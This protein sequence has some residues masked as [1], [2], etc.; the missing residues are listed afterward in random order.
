MTRNKQVVADQVITTLGSRLTLGITV[1]P[2][3]TASNVILWVSHSSPSTDN[4][5]L[6]SSTVTKL[7]GANFTTRQDVI[8]GLPRAIANHAINSIHFGPDGK[9]Y[10]AQGGNTGAGAPNTA[11]TEFGTRA[12]QPLSAAFLVADVKAAGF[13]GT[14]ATPENTLWPVAVQRA[15]V[16]FGPAQHV[17]LRL[18][19]ERLRVR[20]GKRPGRDRQFPAQADGALRR[21]RRH[22]QLDAGRR[23]PGHPARRPSTG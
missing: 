17:R 12:E 6:N 8:T 1:D 15:G 18:A 19:L 13:D 23:Q 2:A 11:N 3:S 7:S 5:E 22:D 21:L 14:C 16:L 20:A 4:G 9:L 10:I